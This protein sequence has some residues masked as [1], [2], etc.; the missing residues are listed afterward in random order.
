[1]A[2]EKSNGEKVVESVV[3]VLGTTLIMGVLGFLVAGPAGAVAGA[4]IG[5]AVTSGHS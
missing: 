4:K 1:M 2:D 3:V 5:A